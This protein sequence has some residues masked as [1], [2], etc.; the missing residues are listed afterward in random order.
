MEPIRILQFG[1]SPTKYYG[2]ESVILNL[3]RHI[4]RS[5]YQFD[6]LV[7][8]K[9]EAIDYEAEVEALGG[10][11]YR[12]YYALNEKNQ[13]GYIS[14]DQFWSLHPE[15]QGGAHLNLDCY[16]NYRTQLIA[17]AKKRGLPIR[18]IHM[19]SA[20]RGSS[21]SLRIRIRHPLFLPFITQSSNQL[22][23]C[24]ETAGRYGFQKRPYKI[25]PNAIDTGKFAFDQAVRNQLRKQHGL[26]DKLVLGFAGRFVSEKNPEFLLSILREVNRRCDHAQLVLLG[27]GELEDSLRRAARQ[28]GLENVSFQG[29][30]DNVHQWMQAFD[31]LLLPSRYEGLPLVLVEAQTAGLMCVASNNVPK[32]TAVTPRLSF[33]SLKDPAAWAE[34]ILHTDFSFDRRKGQ[35]EVAAAGYDI[36]ESS[37]RLEAIYDSLFR[38]ES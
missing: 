11:V 10:H 33:L 3:Y 6:F 1:F 37:K 38:Q 2:T 13:Q 28:M 5:R 15:I 16:D 20:P 35:A 30:V 26:T 8:H 12:Q 25:L 21:V 4:D 24:S 14:P 29:R 9:Y 31:V 27:D 17:A 7:D 36:K 22:L 23:A 19:H 34:A 18:I 32:D